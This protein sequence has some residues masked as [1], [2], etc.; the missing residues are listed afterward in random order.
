MPIYVYNAGR[1]ITKI[2][3]ESTKVRPLIALCIVCTVAA[4]AGQEGSVHPFSAS[5]FAA[6]DHFGAGNQL[7]AS[8]SVTTTVTVSQ[9]ACPPGQVP[10]SGG[11][12]CS[13]P[14]YG[15]QLQ[16][17]VYA[18]GV[19]SPLQKA[20]R[21]A[22]LTA[23]VDR[24]ANAHLLYRASKKEES[25]LLDFFSGLGL[26]TLRFTNK[27]H[28]NP[29]LQGK[30]YGGFNER[31]L[32]GF[33][34]F[35]PAFAVRTTGVSQYTHIATGRI[36]NGAWMLVNTGG[37][38]RQDPLQGLRDW[39][40]EGAKAAA[41]TGKVHFYYGLD[42]SLTVRHADSNGCKHISS[43]CIGV[44]HSFEVKLSNGKSRTM[45]GDAVNF[46][47]ASY[48]TAWELMP[49]K[50][51]ISAVFD[52][53]L[54]CANDIGATGADD[55]TGRGR[56]DIGCLAYQAASI[57]K[58]PLGQEVAAGGRCAF[59]RYWRALEGHIYT[60]QDSIASP[61]QR[62]F[63][64]VQLADRQVDRSADAYVMDRYQHGQ[65]IRDILAGTGLVAGDNY[66][67]LEFRNN[68]LMDED[69]DFVMSSTDFVNA[70]FALLDK[71]NDFINRGAFIDSGAWILN[72][73]GNHGTVDPGEVYID[74]HQMSQPVVMSLYT[75]LVASGKVHFY[76]GL[77]GSLSGRDKGSPSTYR[78]SSGCTNIESVCIGMPYS[79]RLGQRRE[80]SGTSFSTPLGFAAYLMAWERMPANTHISAVFDMALDCV[81]D[82]GAPGPDAETGLGRLDIGCMAYR[83]TQ[84]PEC[85]F[86]YVLVSVSPPSCERFSYWDDLQHPLA[87]VS[88]DGESIIGRAFRDV[89]IVE[90][91]ADRSG[92]I[93]A[94]VEDDQRSFLSLLGIEAGA[95]YSRVSTTADVADAYRGLASSELF[96]LLHRPAPEL[97]TSNRLAAPGIDR[98]DVRQG[99]WIVALVGQQPQSSATVTA[100]VSGNVNPL[101]R[102]SGKQRRKGTKQVASTGKV[103]FLYGLDEKVAGRHSA[104]DGC[105]SI[106]DHCI[107][108]PYHYSYQSLSVSIGLTA[109][110]T[111]VQNRTV[112]GNRLGAAFG[113]A[114]YLTAWERLPQTDTVADLFRIAKGC[115][116]DI[117]AAGADDETGLGRLDIGCLAYETARRASGFWETIRTHHYDDRDDDSSPHQQAFAAARIAGR[118]A[119]RSDDAYVADGESHGHL[120]RTHLAGA[121]INPDTNYKY[122]EI[123]NDFARHYDFLLSS[124]DFLNS[125]SGLG[126]NLSDF[127]SNGA[128]FIYSAGNHGNVDPTA[129]YQDPAAVISLLRKAVASGKMHFYYGLSRDSL[130]VRDERSSGCKYMESA[131]IGTPYYY[132]VRSTL[133]RGT[134]FSAPFAFAAYLMAWERMPANTHISAVYDMALD[135]VEDLGEPGPDADTGLGRLDIGCLAWR[136]AR[137]PSCQFGYVLVSVSPASCQRFSYWE[138]L[139]HPLAVVSSDGES[140][141]ERA[142]N[143]VGLQARAVDR[144][145]RAHAVDHDS[146]QGFLEALGV[147]AAVNYSYI[148]STADVAQEY[149]RLSSSD[150]FGLLHQPAAEVFTNNQA[151]AAGIDGRSVATG[152]WIV[153]PVSRRTGL[154]AVGEDNSL[155]GLAAARR[156]GVKAAAA[157]GKVHFLYG[158]NNKL[159]GR[160]SESDG[161]ANIKEHCIGVP[162]T[163]SFAQ[164][165]VLASPLGAKQIS[166]S[167]KLAGND[168]GARFGFAS[169]LL[170]W[171][172]MPQEVSVSDLFAIVEG[173]VQDIGREGADNATGLGRLDIGCLAF[174]AYRKSNPTVLLS[175]VV[176]EPAKQQLPFGRA[177]DAFMDDFAQGLF[178][179]QLGYLVL[180]GA[181]QAKVQVGFPGDSFS[182]FYRPV[183]SEAHY[184]AAPFHPRHAPLLPGFGLVAT[185]SQVGVYRQLGPDLR[186][187]LLAG[188]GSSFFG[189]GGSG[190]FA[191]GCTT[192]VRLAVSAD[193]HA[194][195]ESALGLTGWLQS[196][197]AGCIRGQLLDRL[198]GSEAG[199]SAF[200]TRSAGDWRLSAQA[201][202]S[203]FVGGEVELAG[204]RFAIGQGSPSYGGRVRLS[205]SF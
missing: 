60:D 85:Q 184:S 120:I 119:D 151:K 21:F 43:S 187:G 22:G 198:Q 23:R 39:E 73:V 157:T 57:G 202:G 62:A 125:S 14:D 175:T 41:A 133:I 102:I 163:Y 105:A 98:S 37:D 108:V 123:R 77:N 8:V 106:R 156:K 145:G 103:H 40:Q 96:G 144:S 138:D 76:Y 95:N 42:S 193:L 34:N 33:A 185:G 107:G 5:G 69:Y 101:S 111:V 141:V 178:G 72:A 201:W 83:T 132:T 84:A 134:S 160:H 52:L 35:A 64:A 36:R 115:V 55:D 164:V 168:A 17:H 47:F 204:E 142:F 10:A 149:G 58:C 86:G 158:L 161:C 186:A 46:A 11:S 121:G 49:A 26:S 6:S 61:Q 136:T 28:G 91:T 82:I 100:V 127:R 181:A 27:R 200:Y 75:D 15:S 18:A 112:S 99:A 53:A 19:E 54:K 116:D 3:K 148:P 143:D 195:G 154:S 162:Y 203:R 110:A 172:R 16:G 113:F 104:S 171:E 45:S 68:Y 159:D 180:P 48:L 29:P 177:S 126:T 147:A 2:R 97:F 12:G 38:G 93:H 182:G 196:S 188:R 174:E 167:F 109:T 165:T 67:Y 137:A 183:L 176:I 56:L 190:E 90:R 118:T 24:S 150:L 146:W 78:G 80:I 71:Y 30:V 9:P 135:C 20:F 114:A 173:C 169:Y 199:I 194:D 170:A 51:D 166:A 74:E 189:S 32:I 25:R 94:A 140:I 65:D 155:A 153:S 88:G 117:G 205:Y 63:A 152:A 130:E 4:Q 122:L 31:Q 179:D 79:V 7:Q 70:S 139:Q 81:D 13:I 131:C 192:D 50:T 44:P 66:T 124:S 1:G 197:R 89:G 129:A 87:V 128:W 92:S 59:L 191:F